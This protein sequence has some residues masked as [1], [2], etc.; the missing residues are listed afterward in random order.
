M[1]RF[2]ERAAERNGAVTPT[3]TNA[4]IEEDED[5]DQDF[6]RAGGARER[7]L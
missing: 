1:R 6:N 2:R 7:D 4:P 3:V 5:L